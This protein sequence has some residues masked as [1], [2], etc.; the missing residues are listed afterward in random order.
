MSAEVLPDRHRKNLSY[1]AAKPELHPLY[2][3]A[4]YQSNFAG[5]LN[6]ESNLILHFLIYPVYMGI[7]CLFFLFA[8]TCGTSINTPPSYYFCKRFNFANRL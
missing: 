2:K 6:L 1:G 4:C 8:Y 7:I 3:E 5:T